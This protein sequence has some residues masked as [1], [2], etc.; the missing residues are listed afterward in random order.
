M[1]LKKK[2]NK[3]KKTCTV[4]FTISKEAAKGA[5]AAWIVGDFNNWSSCENPMEKQEDGSF[6]IVLTLESDKD[7]QFR[8]LMDGKIWENDW[9]AD[10]YEPA[11]F[12]YIENSVVSLFAEKK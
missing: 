8:Y 2:F 12:S 11:P 3:S 4:T 5:N 1:A 9:D 6:S 10:R 7:Y